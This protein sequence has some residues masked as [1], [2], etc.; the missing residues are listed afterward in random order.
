MVKRSTLEFIS[1]NFWQTNR[2]L[3][4]P[5]VRFLLYLILHQTGFI[6]PS[7]IWYL[8]SRYSPL[9]KAVSS[10]LTI[11][12]LSRQSRDGIFSVTL[13]FLSK[14]RILTFSEC[15]PFDVRTFL[16]C[17]GRLPE[18]LRIYFLLLIIHHYYPK[19]KFVHKLRNDR[20]SSCFEFLQLSE[21][22]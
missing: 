12:P 14:L 17:S 9:N 3:R 8:L 4:I 21:V 18:F 13:S 20:F 6:M 10:Y 5:N 15:L 11:S 16:P 2:V 1:E 19:S 7:P 22:E